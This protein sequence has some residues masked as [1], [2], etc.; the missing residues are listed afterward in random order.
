MA[1]HF[2]LTFLGTGT[3][4]GVP[5]IGCDCAVCQSTDPRNKRTRASIL[6]ETPE[7]TLLV[8]SGPDLRQQALRENIRAL[9]GVIYTHGHL[10][11]VTGFDDLRAFCWFREAP[12]PMHATEECMATL[13]S[14]FGWAFSPD[15]T[16]RGYVKPDPKIMDGAFSYG[17]LQI[18]P[19]AVEHASVRTV[20]FRFDY[21]GQRSVA[22]FPDAK[23]FPKETM[24]AIRGIDVLIVDALRP[25]FHPTHFSNDEALAVIAESEAREAWLTHL[26]HDNEHSSLEATLPR[27]VKVSYDGLKLSLAVLA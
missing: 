20:G 23:A 22:Y 18:T 5:I 16:Y 2:T 7:V 24:D 14:M 13:K 21:P 26:G 1:D 27:H 19:L 15:N 6:V 4:T 3:S 25:G 11:H 12:L 8:D 17:N 10:D 9:D